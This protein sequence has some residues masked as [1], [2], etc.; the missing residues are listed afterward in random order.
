MTNL[1]ESFWAEILSREA[2]RIK[3]AFEVLS[4][5]EKVKVSEHLNKMV[6]E[7]GWHHEQV[8]SALAALEVILD[9]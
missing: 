4:E 5:D 1:F 8:I 7:E 2:A 9:E 3:A 6:S